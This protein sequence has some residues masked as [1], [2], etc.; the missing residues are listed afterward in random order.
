VGTLWFNLARALGPALMRAPH[1]GHDPKND[2][3]RRVRH[4]I[5]LGWVQQAKGGCP[6][7][8]VE[9]AHPLS[10]LGFSR[11]IFYSAHKPVQIKKKN[12]HHELHLCR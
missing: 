10:S 7:R 3:R 6:S 2:A 8:K 11:K 12:E 9:D 5:L 4:S 1:A